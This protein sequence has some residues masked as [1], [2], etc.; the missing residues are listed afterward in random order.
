MDKF[1]KDFIKIFADNMEGLR[2]SPLE[3]AIKNGYIN[4]TGAEG[5]R[6]ITYVCSENRTENYE[7][8]EEKVRAA[9]Y[10]ELI[11]C[12]DYPPNRIKVEVTIPD[13]LPSDRADI[14]VFAD[15]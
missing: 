10:S 2:L 8:P 15:D 7:N 6:K 4:I 12:Y 9:F 11:Y 13:R 14:V 1:E 3:K 5:K